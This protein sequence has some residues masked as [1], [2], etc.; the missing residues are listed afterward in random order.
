MEF[1]RLSQSTQAEWVSTNAD[2]SVERRDD[3][4]V[5][6]DWVVPGLVREPGSELR[7]SRVRLRDRDRPEEGTSVQELTSEE[8]RLAI[9]D[10][11]LGMRGEGALTTLCLRGL[12]IGRHGS[13]GLILSGDG[14]VGSFL[15]TCHD[16]I[17]LQLDVSQDF[18]CAQ[19]SNAPQGLEGGR[20]STRGSGPSLTPMGRGVGRAG[21]EGPG[22]D[23]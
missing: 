12:V 21:H 18:I 11:R 9:R 10:T 6:F 4:P 23:P 14:T 8:G 20:V 5:E 19:G 16:F 17:H 7:L 3:I 2:H 13:P 22:A 15:G 1:S